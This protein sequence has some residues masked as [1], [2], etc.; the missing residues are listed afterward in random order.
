MYERKTKKENQPFMFP[1]KGRFEGALALIN[2]LPGMVYRCDIVPDD[3]IYSYVSDGCLALTGYTAEELTGDNAVAFYDILHAEDVQWVQKMSEETV[4]V[5]LPFE[6]TYRIITKDGSVKWVWE[7]SVV[8][9]YGPDG[10]PSVLE[11]FDTDV[12]EF[13]RLQKAEEEFESKIDMLNIAINDAKEANTAKSDFLAKMSHEIRTPMNA[14]IGMTELALREE[15]SDVVRDYTNSARQAGIDLL[16]IINDILDFSK[17]ESG[18]MNI[19]QSQYSLSSLLNDVI[20][21][22][23]T[24]LVNSR[25]RLI[26]YIDSNLP[27]SLIGDE[28]RARQILINS[29]ENAVKYTDKGFIT[30][31]VRGA[32]TKED[33]V[34][35]IFKVRDS[36]RGIKEEDLANVFKSYVQIKS[37]S[38]TQ[39]EGV[40]LGLVIS[41]DL[42]KAMGGDITVESEFGVGSTFTIMLPQQINTS[43][44]LASVKDAEAI[45]AIVCE[46]CHESAASIAYAITNLGAECT[47][48]S[49]TGELYDRF[50]KGS[51][52]YV[53]IPYNLYRQEKEML[54]NL[55]RSTQIVLLAE[56]GESITAFNCRVVSMPVNSLSVASVFSSQSNTFITN[57]VNEET[58]VRFT[59]PDAKILV[60]DDISTNL[61]VVKGLLS[62]YLMEVDLCLSGMEAIEAVKEKRY[63]LIFMDHRMPEMDGIETTDHIRALESEG[64]RYN[65]N[66]PIVA[67]TANAVAGVKEIFLQCGFDDFMSKPI[68]TVLFNTILERWL[69]KEKQIFEANNGETP[70]NDTGPSAIE[71]DGVDTVKGIRLSG[72]ALENYLEILEIFHEDGLNQ[73]EEIKKHMETGDLSK[74]SSGAHAIKG[75]LSSIGADELSEL[76][77]A[78]EKAGGS[79][80]KDF[81]D[82]N[83]GAFLMRLDKL[84]N[85]VEAAFSS[86]KGKQDDDTKIDEQLKNVLAMLKRALD[87][88]DGYEINKNTESMF[89][90]SCSEEVK[91][92]LRTISKSIL[93]AEYDEATDLIESLLKM[94]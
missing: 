6:A 55:D 51:Y 74:I 24:K 94:E 44:K 7:R 64:D 85:D 93:M 9:E 15:M 36:G 29:L 10:K 30:F 83:S 63:D 42:A 45:T 3:Y 47:K 18:N 49:S 8:A 71:I 70:L 77:K 92:T 48:V 84:L 65:Y 66:V 76:A 52:K 89:A 22:I 54:Q 72:G 39:K 43:T 87:D 58:T 1:E 86:C 81:I 53:F 33:T 13:L 26:T 27:E 82:S 23:R 79:A 37:E 28:T 88:M 32:K 73:R 91:S 75:A 2:S 80:D 19:T 41:K 67:L 20:S 40:G 78:L 12:T 35:L 60:V 38:D 14:I 90:F 57:N 5:G 31:I 61:K 16:N 4:A 59:A 21:V 62:P 69:P 17:I 56:F 34:N 50:K 46:P 11:G 25:V 68:D